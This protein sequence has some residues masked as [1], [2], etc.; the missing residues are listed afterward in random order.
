MYPRTSEQR[1]TK[2]GCSCR[3]LPETFACTPIH[4]HEAIRT[5]RILLRDPPFFL[6]LGNCQSWVRPIVLGVVGVYE[7]VVELTGHR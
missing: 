2:F 5:V 3:K 7:G 1:Q 6:S 4:Y